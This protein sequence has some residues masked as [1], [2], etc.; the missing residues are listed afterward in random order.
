[1]TAAAALPKPPVPDAGRDE[2][3]YAVLY[4]AFRRLVEHWADSAERPSALEE[5]VALRAGSLVERVLSGLG[6]D[7]ER[8][9]EILARRD[10][11]PSQQERERR[12][13]LVAGLENMIDFAA[14]EEWSMC[15]E[16]PEELHEEEYELCDGIF[17]RYN[18]RRAAQENLDV[19][20]AA[21]MAAWWITLSPEL[22][23]TFTTQGDERVRPGHAALE[24]V[25]YPKHEFPA[26]L[27]PPIEY[28][29]RCYLTPTGAAAVAGAAVVDT[30]E[31]DPVFGESLCRGG[32]I[33]SAAHPYFRHP[34]PP[35][36]QRYV[37][38]VKQKFH[39]P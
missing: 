24:G 34:L 4:A 23:L 12:D 22:M 16:L 1:M 37:D 28:G 30:T 38:T 20:F 13:I 29:C 21:S 17:D 7:L 33:F 25:S 3:E 35:A 18:G 14:A 39:L 36:L 31:I 10:D 2:A 19:Q 15:R 27:I 5:L 26:E 9:L 32:R 6:L 11:F 8:A